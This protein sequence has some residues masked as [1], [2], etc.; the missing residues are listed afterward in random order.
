M[1]DKEKQWSSI[2]LANAFI[3]T[4]RTS[5]ETSPAACCASICTTSGWTRWKLRQR[6]R[7]CILSK[8]ETNIPAPRDAR[9]ASWRPLFLDVRF[10]FFFPI[11]SPHLR[12]LHQLPGENLLLLRHVVAVLHC[13]QGKAHDNQMNAFNL[14][15]CIAPSML[16]APAP[17]TAE[18]EGE[19][20]K[21]VRKRTVETNCTVRTG[22]KSW[23]SALCYNL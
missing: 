13:I 2:A 22:W 20:T 7:R 18:M 11:W 1:T 17:S 19:G 4:T 21:K 10:H 6:T 16:W 3:L 5:C 9:L 15:V 23:C 12:L 8:G 14:S